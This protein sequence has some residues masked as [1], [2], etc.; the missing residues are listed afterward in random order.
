MQVR[1]E[2]YTM[3]HFTLEGPVAW[4]WCYPTYRM[5]R[6]RDNVRVFVHLGAVVGVE[7]ALRSTEFH[8]GSW[9]EL[10]VYTGDRQLVFRPMYAG[11][12]WG[13]YDDHAAKSMDEFVNMWIAYAKAHPTLVCAGA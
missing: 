3:S 1:V 6:G 11:K 10:T 5:Q 8:P 13:A 9:T 12:T 4:T 7:V 2:E